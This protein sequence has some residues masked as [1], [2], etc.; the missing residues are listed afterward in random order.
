MLLAVPK[1]GAVPY[2]RLSVEC[3]AHL[4]SVQP[5]NARSIHLLQALF[6]S[7]LHGLAFVSCACV[8]P[9]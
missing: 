9:L 1:A 6:L 8:V 5:D 3:I 7:G 2:M 4:L